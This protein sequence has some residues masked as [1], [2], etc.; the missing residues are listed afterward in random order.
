MS[1]E[2]RNQVRVSFMAMIVLGLLIFSAY[3]NTFNSPPV[4]DDIHS[5]I[6]EPLVQ[7]FDWSPE[8]IVALTKTKFGLSRF[9]PM[10]TLANDQWRA[11]GSL[12]AFHATNLIIHLLVTVAVFFWSL[13]IFLIIADRESR[14][15]SNSE[16][17]AS[18]AITGLWAL[19]PVQTNA[20]TYIVQR[21]ASMA[22]LFYFLAFSMYFAGRRMWKK[23]R[24]KSAFIWWV[25]AFTSFVVSLFCKQN[26]V[27]LPVVILAGELIFYQHD[28]LK[29]FN[30][31]SIVLQA[32]S[33]VFLVLSFIVC[34]KIFLYFQHSYD[35][36]RFSMEERLL[37]ESRV[38]ISYIFL[39]LVP[40]PSFLCLDRHVMVSHSLWQPPTTILSIGLL[41]GFF[42]L[43]F[44]SWK[45]N[46]LLCFGLIWFFL[47]LIIES[48][49][50]PLELMFEHRLYLPSAGFYLFVVTVLMV[51][52]SKIF[53]NVDLRLTASVA[54]IICA[55]LSSLTYVRNCD[56]A[57]A[58]TI[59]T[60]SV[61]KS[62]LK[63]RAYNNLSKAYYMAGNYRKA[64]VNAEKSISLGV[65][66]Y[67]E[68][69]ASACNLVSS[70]NK[71]GHKKEAWMR[72][73]E[74]ITKAPAGAKVNALP[75]FLCNQAELDIFFQDYQAAYKNLREALGILERSKMPFM[76][77]VEKKLC[78]LFEEA[79]EKADDQSIKYLGLVS[80]NQ[81]AVYLRMAILYEEFYDF[82]RAHKYALQALAIDKDC[83]QCRLLN[84]KLDLINAE[85]NRQQKNGTLKSKYVYNFW[86]SSFNFCMML[87]YVIEKYH[88]PFD[89]L[90]LSC[91]DKASHLRP[92]SP[93]PFLLYSWFYYRKGDC[94]KAIQ[95]VEKG[96]ELNIDYA[97]LWINLGMYQ[98]SSKKYEAANKSLLKALS[99]Y[100]AY[101]KRAQILAMLRVTERRTISND[102]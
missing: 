31:H 29:F 65:Y 68:Y 35:L 4:L 61:A 94:Q 95:F 75:I 41:F 56:W 90:A 66:G 72:G 12:S 76:P 23:K 74:L 99:L 26:A 89:R 7:H 93:D 17:L 3:S 64:A 15:L 53:E 100:P 86:K 11:G 28:L 57:D 21:M 77:I 54:V 36:R 47:N 18:L 49:V 52:A 2:K 40:L 98:L 16:L 13:I 63:S 71:L 14:S 10:L 37:T 83:E 6:D 97:Q 84:A 102:I 34:L 85:N 87:A 73:R 62:P 70:L 45:R 32:I 67:E 101:P 91:L 51:L 81:V 43:I 20:V 22:A 69:W 44:F 33:A 30:R 27:M 39:L 79:K 60:D 9:L 24:R 78:K 55:A 96:M 48:T 58:I 50:V 1:V 88:L 59:N 42:Y 5:F 92:D 8:S 82:Q 19:A 25:F 46:P 80:R 38:V